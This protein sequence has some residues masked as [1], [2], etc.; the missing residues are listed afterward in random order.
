M[1]VVVRALLC[2]AAAF[3]VAAAPATGPLPE[4]IAPASVPAQT[5]AHE[6]HA[7]TRSDVEAWLD[8]FFPQALARADIAGAVVVVVK[9]GQVLTEKGYGFS[10]VEKRKPVDPERT[11]FR[12]ASISK[13]FTWTA[14]M[15]LAEQHRLDLD[16]DV[17]AYL[18]FKIPASFPK[19][20]TL[21]NLMTHTSGFEEHIKG[22]MVDAAAPLPLRTALIG[23]LPRRIYPPGEVSAY[24]NYGAALAGYIVQRVSGE[25]FEDYVAR[26]IFAP[27]GMQHATFVQ[28]LPK[29]LAADMSKGY[30]TASQG[31]KPFEVLS[32]SP[33]GALS[34]SGADIARFMIAHLGDGAYGGGRILKRETAIAMHA[35]AFQPVPPLPPMALGFWHDDANGH[36]IVSHDG[37]LQY[38]HS[39]LHLILDQNVGLFASLNSAGRNEMPFRGTRELLFNGFMDRYFPGPALASARPLASAAADARKVAGFYKSSRRSETNFLRT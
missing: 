33:A 19:P 25:R 22:L 34:V 6:T 20:I 13:L 30:L 39:E 11:L 3:C 16:R 5:A 17:N 23:S 37:D 12:P 2:V 15:Q 1:R 26:H 29:A 4:T 35:P 36:S 18:D 31:A 21:R 38:F 9:D 28:P 7:L 14:V 24:S 10:D 32:L 27:L 8:G